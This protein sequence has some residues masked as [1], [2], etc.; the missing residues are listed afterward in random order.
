MVSRTPDQMDTPTLLYPPSSSR[1]KISKAGPLNPWKAS[2]EEVLTTMSANVIESESEDAA[3]SYPSIIRAILRPLSKSAAYSVHLQE[4]RRCACLVAELQSLPSPCSSDDE[5]GA[6][7]SSLSNTPKGTPIAKERLDKGQAAIVLRQ[8]QENERFTFGASPNNDVVL[9]HPEQL[10]QEPCYINLLHFQLYPDPDYEALH[11]YNNSGSSFAVSSLPAP[12]LED[13]LLPGHHASLEHGSWRLRLGN[14]LDFEI[15][16]MPYTPEEAVYH[17]SI[18]SPTRE[19]SF[20]KAKRTTEIVGQPKRKTEMAEQS[21]RAIPKKSLSRQTG[22]EAA[23]AG[24]KAL[25]AGLLGEGSGRQENPELQPQSH[26]KIPTPNETIGQNMRTQVFKANRNGM[27]VA[28][29]ACRKPEL[30][31]SA[32]TWRNELQILRNVHHVSLSK[33]LALRDLNL[34]QPSIIKLIHYNAASLTLELEYIGPDLSHFIDPQRVSQLSED[35]Q[36]RVWIDISH[37]INYMHSESIIHLDIK[38]ENI[39]LSAGGRAVLCD[40]GFSIRGAANTVRNSSGTPCYIPPEYISRHRRGFPGDIWAF[41]VTLLFVFGLI[42]LPK[43]S[44][45][46]A[47]VFVQAYSEMRGWLRKVGQTSENISEE[48]SLL[49]SMLSIETKERITASQLVN[50]LP[51]TMPSEPIPIANVI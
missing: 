5:D 20:A 47:D 45:K 10:D 40:F 11:L 33:H 2:V 17:A 39:L 9:K 16:I 49:R 4:N 31:V 43:G 48:L 3:E 51:A 50:S 36:H 23:S 15:R 19:I 38:P 44:W 8:S 29:K 30:K 37:G 28:I 32:E 34:Q 6:Q 14:G 22:S 26:S 24:K 35:Q 25:E 46:I 42:P 7:K 41:G 27:V 13:N 1:A 18:I 12:R 21:K